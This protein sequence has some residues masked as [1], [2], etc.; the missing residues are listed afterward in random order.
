MENLHGGDSS[1]GAGLVCGLAV[2][3]TLMGFAAGGAGGIAMLSVTGSL[4][5]FSIWHASSY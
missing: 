1:Y 5:G 3:G 4:C 2:A